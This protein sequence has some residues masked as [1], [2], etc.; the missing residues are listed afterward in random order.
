MERKI[1][2]KKWRE[3]LEMHVEWDVDRRHKREKVERYLKKKTE[4]E[5]WGKG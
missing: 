2:S 5:W 3:N 1:G 4:W